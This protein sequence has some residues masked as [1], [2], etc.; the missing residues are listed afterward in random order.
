MAGLFEEG[1]TYCGLQVQH[2]NSEE[3]LSELDRTKEECI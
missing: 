2:T 1:A 3:Q